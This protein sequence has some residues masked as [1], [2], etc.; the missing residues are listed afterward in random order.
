MRKECKSFFC[1]FENVLVDSFRSLNNF[2]MTVML[3]AAP[4][5]FGESGEASPQCVAT[6]D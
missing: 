3:L 6:M 2:G 5:T 4:F 1:V